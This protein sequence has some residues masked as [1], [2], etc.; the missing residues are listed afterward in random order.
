[1]ETFKPVI[2]DTAGTNITLQAPPV[3]DFSE[4][5]LVFARSLSKLLEGV[6][7]D[8]EEV[9]AGNI[10]PVEVPLPPKVDMEEPAKPPTQTPVPRGRVETVT[11]TS[12]PLEAK[13]LLDTLA[14][15]ESRGYDI[16][17]G[18]GMYGAPAKLTDYSQHPNVIG[19][20]TSA[21][22]STAAGRYQFTYSTWKELQK[23]Y[24]GQFKDFN[25]VTQDRAAWRYAQDVYKQRTGRDLTEA[26]KSG[27]IK[28]VQN[29]LRNIWI[30]FGLDKDVA[31]TYAKALGRYN[32][33]G[34]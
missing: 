10:V 21:G 30:G 5:A 14:R 22:P 1:M 3:A 28:T 12:L 19:M 2:E 23:N 26:L 15:Y 8:K 24:P 11:D 6:K 4:N 20:R 27:N 32:K 34:N 13:A 31:G 17:V 9:P 16:I 29:T 25:P 7:E 33:N 18:E